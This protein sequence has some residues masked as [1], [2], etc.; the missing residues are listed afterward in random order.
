MELITYTFMVFLLFISAFITNKERIKGKLHRTFYIVIILVFI[1][2]IRS[3]P[4]ADM[5]VYSREMTLPF[6]SMLKN[7]YYLREFVFWL[8]SSF[9]TNLFKSTTYSFWFWDILTL[10]AVLR[11]RKNFNLPDYYIL[12]YYGT[13][14]TLLGLE[15]IYRQFIATTFLLLSISYVLKQS[16]LKSLFFLL[17]AVFSHNAV[18]MFAPL[19]LLIYPKFKKRWKLITLLVLI[20]EL[21]TLPILMHSKSEAETGLELKYVYLVVIFATFFPLIL[22]GKLRFRKIDKIYFN[23]FIFLFGVFAVALFFLGGIVE[24]VG[25]IALIVLQP[26]V[27]QFY[28]KYWNIAILRFYILFIY[29]LPSYIFGATMYF[30]ENKLAFLK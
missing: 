19:Y 11:I 8:S 25:M 15:N 26:F 30:L 6:E 3:F 28:E 9:I 1:Y 20:F 4:Q 22:S 2:T 17:L 7:T 24:R 12:L 23:V 29:V 16:K 21:V 5:I 18:I 14:I 27:L 10:L 13:F